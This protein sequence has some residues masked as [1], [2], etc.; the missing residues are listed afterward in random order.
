MSPLEEDF[1]SP[2]RWRSGHRSEQGTKTLVLRTW[3]PDAIRQ[4]SISTHRPNTIAGDV[5]QRS[6]RPADRGEVSSGR[7]P[8]PGRGTEFLAATELPGFSR[9]R[10]INFGVQRKNRRDDLLDLYPGDAA[11]VVWTLDYSVSGTDV[12]GPYIQGPP[13]G[14]FI[15][16]KALGCHLQSQQTWLLRRVPPRSPPGRSVLGWSG[17]PLARL[18]LPRQWSAGFPRGPDLIRVAD[19]GPAAVVVDCWLHSVPRPAGAR[20]AAGPPGVAPVEGCRHRHRRRGAAALPHHPGRL[21]QRPR[22]LRRDRRAS[23]EGP[24]DPTDVKCHWRGLQQTR[25]APGQIG[26]RL[27]AQSTK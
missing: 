9:I 27:G 23:Q 17:K 18:T 25:R 26:L 16:L 20:P 4:R 22:P 10:P 14:R 12:R 15:Y 6:P 8:N 11:T 21:S 19:P 5:Q 7:R 1:L 13:G 2:P 3:E 24:H